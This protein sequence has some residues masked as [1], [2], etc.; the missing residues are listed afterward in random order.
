MGFVKGKD[1]E[2]IYNLKEEYVLTILNSK[3]VNIDEFKNS[4]LYRAHETKFFIEK[5]YDLFHNFNSEYHSN[6]DK[7]IDLSKLAIKFENNVLEIVFNET[8]NK[9]NVIDKRIFVNGNSI[10]GRMMFRGTVSAPA[11]PF[12]KQLEALQQFH[13]DMEGY[14]LRRE[15]ALQKSWEFAK[16]YITRH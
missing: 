13:D 2:E 10:T 3:G 7:Q 4:E 1:P 8:N 12:E 6:N 11:I 16:T 9:Y 5:L 15:D 14:R